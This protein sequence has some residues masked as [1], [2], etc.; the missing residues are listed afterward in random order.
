MPARRLRRRPRLLTRLHRR[1]PL[2]ARPGSARTAMVRMRHDSREPG[3]ALRHLAVRFSGSL[4][5]RALEML[6]LDEYKSQ[7]LTESELQRLLGF[8][9]RYELDGFLKAH[10]VWTD[11]SIEDLREDLQDLDNLG[12]GPMVPMAVADTGPVNYLILIEYI[13]ILPASSRKS[14]CQPSSG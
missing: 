9:T 6:A 1:S 2:A 10:Q 13:D 14:S 12:L 3:I 8:G 4:S 7:P 5:R 11:V